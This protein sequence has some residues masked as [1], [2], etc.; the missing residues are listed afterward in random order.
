MDGTHE[1]EPQRRGCLKENQ[2][3]LRSVSKDNGVDRT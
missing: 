2:I 1:E 3:L